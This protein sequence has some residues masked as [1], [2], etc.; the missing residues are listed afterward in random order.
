M[1]DHPLSVSISVDTVFFSG[2][3]RVVVEKFSEKKKPFFVLCSLFLFTLEGDLLEQSQ[4]IK[5][6]F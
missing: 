3:E 1:K 5:Q 4:E 2:Q 6:R